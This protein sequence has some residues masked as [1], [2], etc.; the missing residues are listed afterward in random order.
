MFID[1]EIVRFRDGITNRPQGDIFNSMRQPDPTRFHQ[2]FEDFDIFNSAAVMAGSDENW[3]FLR[4]NGGTGAIANVSGNGGR[5]RL[6][7]SPDGDIALV[8][9]NNAWSVASQRR[10]FFKAVIN[11]PDVASPAVSLGLF[12]NTGEPADPEDAIW[13]TKFDGDTVFDLRQTKDGGEGLPLQSMGLENAP[14]A[15]DNVDFELA[16]FYDGISRFWAA[17]NGAAVGTMVSDGVQFPDDVVLT[18]F[19]YIADPG[20]TTNYLMDV[21]FLYLAQER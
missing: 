21:D 4:P 5:V 12:A 2:L 6:N 10:V 9:L 15:Q 8:K 13:F 1:N 14:S 16:F 20:D 11:L 19:V 17:Y 18:P 3:Q 7:T